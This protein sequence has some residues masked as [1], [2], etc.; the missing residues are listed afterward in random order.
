MAEALG[1]AKLVL[2]TDDTKFDAGIEEA[3]G[4]AKSLDATF[5][6]VGA[7]LTKIGTGLTAAVTLPILG[8]G[9]AAIKMAV[10]AVEAENLFETSFGDMADAAREWSEETGK[11]LGLNRVELR[12]Q[13]GVI[14]TMTESMGLGKDA[15][16]GMAT[17]ITELAGDMAS[18]FNLRPEEAFAKL[19]SGIAGEA[20]PLKQLGILIDEATIKQTAYN[21]GIAEFGTELTNTQ[22]VQARWLAIQ[23]Q[24]VK[25]Q[26]D[27]ARTLESPANR[28]RALRTRMEETAISL[29]T[30]L[31]P[32]FERLIDVADAITQKIEAMV[33]WFANL[34]PATQNIVIGITAFVAALGPLLIIFGKLIASLKVIIAIAPAVGAAITTMS[35]PF[36]AILLLI[37]A[38]TTAL[39]LMIRETNKLHAETLA[40]VDTT[41][42]LGLAMFDLQQ[43]LANAASEGRELNATIVEAAGA[44]LPKMRKELADAKKKLEEMTASGKASREEIAEQ[45]GFVNELGVQVKRT[46][47]L[48]VQ[49]VE[50][51]YR[52][53]TEAV[54]ALSDQTTDLTSNIESLN[55]Q[56]ANAEELL[57]A[58]GDAIDE[59]LASGLPAVEQMEVSIEGIGES[60]DEFGLDEL[61]RQWEE[62]QEILEKG[63]GTL[64]EWEHLTG[65]IAE[66]WSNIQNSMVDGLFSLLE[67]DSFS[68]VLA[69][70]GGEIGGRLGEKAGEVLGDTLDSVFNRPSFKEKILGFFEKFDAGAA[71]I[72]QVEKAVNLLSKAVNKIPVTALKLLEENFDDIVDAAMRLGGEAVENLR[73]LAEEI[74]KTGVGVE[75]LEAKLRDLRAEADRAFE[76]RAAFIRDQ[77]E[78]MI[79]GIEALSLR[80]AAEVNF[81]ATTV[82]QAFNALVSAGAPILEIVG[83]LGDKFGEIG[84]AGEKLG[85]D[86]GGEFS[87]IGE[88]MTI[89]ADKD[90]QKVVTR[91]ETI[92]NTAT[93]VGELGLLTA[94]QFKFFANNVEGAFNKLVD[95][96][97]ESEEAIA[98]LAP[99]LQQINDLAEKYGVTVGGVTGELLE[100]AKAQGVVTDK[101]LTM[102]DILIKGFDRILESLNRVIV[103]LGGVP[104]AL[105]EIGSTGTAAFGAIQVSSE[106][107]A[108]A[109]AAAWRGSAMETIGDVKGMVQA[110]NQQIDR[111]NIPTGGFGVGGLPGFQHGSGTFRDFGAGT[112]VMLHGTEQVINA[113]EGTGIAQ[114]VRSAMARPNADEELRRNT[115]TLVELGI[116]ASRQRDRAIDLTDEM[117]KK[118]QAERKPSECTFREKAERG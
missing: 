59:G 52:P 10:D 62:G 20:E 55:I 66:G 114:M 31:L 11:A 6:K 97:L 116:H 93:A 82:T 44:A 79:T 88:M 103:A 60:L 39:S 8:I 84:R 85:L 72:G 46:N 5:Q 112:P 104:V 98:A 68:N 26:G 51:G 87:R 43:E 17:G 78:T 23:E 89:L 64:Q 24:T 111:I 73:K 81:A 96:G 92:G 34:P 65:N 38:V 9:T 18:F 57:S 86:L 36:G 40:N 110:I 94:E 63:A 27:L 101:G 1:T 14:F 102:E 117:K 105:N 77:V 83:I 12:K 61:N 33:T 106:Q 56:I 50:Q 7:N 108:A 28:M 71:S 21:T 109:A 30:A 90:M 100:K 42:K 47:Q 75:M 74:R 25:I 19:R 15:A 67:G 95:G 76:E 48:L 29:G 80:S 37:T 4:K 32:L 53:T 13:A 41:H 99:Q 113:S 2:V 58:M 54:D 16:F 22:K 118:M 69:G 49:A 91:L 115:R 3:E 107:A 45:T 35:G 70:I